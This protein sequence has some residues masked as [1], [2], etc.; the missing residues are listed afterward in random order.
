MVEFVGKSW[1]DSPRLSCSLVRHAATYS[2]VL[3][4]HAHTDTKDEARKEGGDLKRGERN[5][6]RK[7]DY[8]TASKVLCALKKR[9]KKKAASK[10]TVGIDCSLSVVFNTFWGFLFNTTL[11]HLYC[12]QSLEF[13]PNS[14]HNSESTTQEHTHRTGPCGYIICTVPLFSLWFPEQHPCCFMLRGVI[15]TAD[16]WCMKA[17]LVCFNVLFFSTG[18]LPLVQFYQF[19]TGVHGHIERWKQWFTLFIKPVNVGLVMNL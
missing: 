4:V 13:F 18:T 8:T 14:L 11:H 10:L 16:I 3:Y 7:E 6:D 2:T 15:P 5:E 17:S 12:V 1:Y 19:Y 9:K